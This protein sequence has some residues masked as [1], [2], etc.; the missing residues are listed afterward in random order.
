MLFQ[1]CDTMNRVYVL[2]NVKRGTVKD[3][4]KEISRLK[5]VSE[6]SIVSGRYDMFAK[7]EGESLPVITDTIINRIHKIVGVERT[8]TLIA[9]DLDITGEEGPAVRAF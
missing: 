5:G 6:V 8:E 7:I 1:I 3:V 2:V 9:L 4:L